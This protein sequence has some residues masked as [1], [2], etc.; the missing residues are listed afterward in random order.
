MLKIK[1][2]LFAI[3]IISVLL[4]SSF[5]FASYTDIDAVLN[6]TGPSGENIDE[7]NYPEYPLQEIESQPVLPTH[8]DLHINTPREDFILDTTVH[9]NV[10]VT[11]R[12]FTLDSSNN[13]RNCKWKSICCSG[14][15]KNLF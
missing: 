15:S 1:L 10:F 2:K 14:D 8:G 5:S 7:Y 6:E 12:N 3:V 11:A 13:R 9:G 4:L